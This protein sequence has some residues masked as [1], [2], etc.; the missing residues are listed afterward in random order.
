M[1]VF[2]D[3]CTRASVCVLFEG[4]YCMCVGKPHSVRMCICYFTIWMNYCISNLLQWHTGLVTDSSNRSADM[5]VWATLKLFPIH[6][7]YISH[8]VPRQIL[9]WFYGCFTVSVCATMDLWPT[10]PCKGLCGCK[11]QK[12]DP[13]PI[14]LTSLLCPS[15][16]LGCPLWSGSSH[17]VLIYFFLCLWWV[18][19]ILL[20][21]PARLTK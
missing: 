6:A 17:N 2:R 8:M 4:V 15:W 20:W 19:N 18:W 21:T 13:V 10:V 9:K 14:T 1:C 5:W 11:I 12:E 3:V 7:Q 16:F